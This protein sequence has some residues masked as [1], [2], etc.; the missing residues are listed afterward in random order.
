VAT[1]DAREVHF[2]NFLN[3]YNV[4]I[5]D[6]DLDKEDLLACY[7]VTLLNGD[8]IKQRKVKVATIQGYFKAA[9]QWAQRNGLDLNMQP[10]STAAQLL[11]EQKR[12]ETLP[13]RRLPLTPAM[14][15]VAVTTLAEGASSLSKLRA[16][17][18]WIAA[19]RLAGF[20]AQEFT[21]EK[22]DTIQYYV[23][24]DGQKIARSFTRNDIVFLDK[25]NNPI[26]LGTDDSS[27]TAVELRYEI[28]KNRENNQK[29]SYSRNTKYPKYCMVQNMIEICNRAN[30]LGQP[31]HLP[32]NVYQD[33]DGVT[34]YMTGD[35]V[36][37]LIRVI[38]KKVMP[39]LSDEELELYSCH[40]LRVTACVL[41]HEA[42]KD[43]TYI[44]LRLRWK[45]ECFQIY[46]R[47]T[48][49][50]RAQH[51][52]ALELADDLLAEMELHNE[53]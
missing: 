40:S 23:T 41:L 17:A 52:E 8:T 35:D 31:N 36:T 20:R 47:N 49:T 39:N 44:K 10:D 42:G 30:Q 18:N 51:T 33:E 53:Q 32:I 6:P 7:A 2:E 28:Q 25:D 21:Q 45:S 9:N 3:K 1:S 43:G 19:G 26:E 11:K 29:I 24:P 13:S 50:I 22:V 38:A 37:E 5:L 48:A 15:F 46:L 34:R 14:I 27:I 12:Y 16:F 4:D